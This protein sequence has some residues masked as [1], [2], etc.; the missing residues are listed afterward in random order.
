MTRL[1]GPEVLILQLALEAQ[2]HATGRNLAAARKR[3]DAKSVERMEAW[4]A[5]TRPLQ[6]RL[7]AMQVAR[8]EVAD[9]SAEVQR[10]RRVE[11]AALRVASSRRG[12]TVSDASALNRLDA[13]LEGRSDD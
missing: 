12:D 3:N 1:T 2:R 9:D 7:N 13:A 4:L 10:L 8:A 6:D 11:A 5:A